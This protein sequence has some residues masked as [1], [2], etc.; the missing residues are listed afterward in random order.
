MKNILNGR[1]SQF[2]QAVQLWMVKSTAAKKTY[3]S[4]LNFCNFSSIGEIH[5]TVLYCTVNTYVLY[6]MFVSRA[7]H[8]WTTVRST[9]DH[10]LRVKTLLLVVPGSTMCTTY[11][12]LYTVLYSTYMYSTYCT[13]YS[14][15]YVQ[16]KT[17]IELA[18]PNSSVRF[19]PAESSLRI[20]HVLNSVCFIIIFTV[21]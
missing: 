11:V 12:L 17:S 16:L 5:S 7:D 2:Y 4:S 3:V 6:C 21:K 18:V 13:L 1:I 15:S 20:K 8:S 9:R 14:Y 19:S 10:V